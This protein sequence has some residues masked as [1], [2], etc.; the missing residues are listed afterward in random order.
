MKSIIRNYLAKLAAGRTDDGIM[1]TLPDPKKINFQEAMIQDLLMRNG[2]DPNAITSE[3]MLKSIL[4]QIDMASKQTAPSGIRGTRSAQILDMEGQTIPQGSQIMGGKAVDTDVDTIVNN[5]KSMEPITAMKEANSVI[6]RKGKYKNLTPEQSKKILQDTEDHIFERDVKPSEFDPDIEDM[7]DGG[8]IGYFMGSKLPKGAA[9]LREMLKFFSKGSAT[10]KTPSEMLQMVNPKQFNR[11]L[12]DPNIYRKFNVQEGIGAPE[13][14]K[15]MQSK[16]GEDRIKMIEEVLGAAKNIKGADDKIVK[17]ETEIIQEMIKKGADPEMAQN[18]AKMLS[19]TMVDAVGKKGTPKLTDEG[20]MQLENILKNMET[21]GKEKRSLN[22]D[23]GRIGLKA[24]MTKR[25]FLKLMGGTGAA[26]GAAKSGIFSGFGKGAGKQAAKEVV[27]Q[28]VRST[29]PPYF[30]ELANK[31]KML[32]KPDKV[33]YAD[34]VEIHRYRGKNG[35]EYELIED[36]NTGDV[37]ITKDKTGVGSYGDKTFDTI[38]DRTVLEYKKGDADV[39]PES[40]TAFKSADEYEEYKVE[41]DADGTPAD[42]TEL[43]AVVQKEIIEEA[44]GDAPSIKK[45]GGGIA[46]MLGE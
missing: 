41:F 1:I 30:F 8:R 6:A 5:I 35:D 3:E 18:I 2:V 20:I 44:T 37:R 40:G 9:A 4:N 38:E 12:E 33:T 17:Y 39:D 29:P 14:I 21:G 16:M 28:G 43:D 10:K 26:I 24:G 32:G 23:G 46:R 19:K 36:L 31:I 11:L 13:M 34:R 15:N 7:A 27:E 45:A 42:A 22:A 25:A